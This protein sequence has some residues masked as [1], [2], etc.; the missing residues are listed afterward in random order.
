MRSGPGRSVAR[1]AAALAVLLLAGGCSHMSGH[2]PW[3]KSPPPPPPPPVHELDISGADAFPQSWKRNTLLVD[4]SA[5]SGSGGVTLKP[6]EGTTWPVRIAF[7]VT[8]G[9]IGELEVHAAQRVVVPISSTSA[10]HID[11]ELAPGVYTPQSPDM[12]VSWG[13]APATP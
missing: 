9:A 13:P 1:C 4:L 11:L 6:A 5:A 12:H 3:H 10:T 7:R 2:W 8:P